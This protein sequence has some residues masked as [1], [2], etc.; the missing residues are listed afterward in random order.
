MT[1]LR[2][3]FYATM[4]AIS[5]FVA[6]PY[7]V[8]YLTA[9]LPGIELGGWRYV[10]FLA[11][12]PGLLLF[13]LPV[14]EFGTKGHGTPAP[15]DPTKRLVVDGVFGYLR[16]PMYLGAFLVLLGEGLLFTSLPLLVVSVVAWVLFH[17]YVVTR[18]EPRLREKFGIDYVEYTK[19]VPRWFPRIR[20][21]R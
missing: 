3:F 19:G 21:N 11:F 12:T 15:F 16:N 2:G 6:L 8:L 14:L 1:L 7:V 4:V 5:A 20:Q 13:Y 18:E 10:G 17:L 9:A